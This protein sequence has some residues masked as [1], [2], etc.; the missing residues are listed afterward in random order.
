V[1]GVQEHHAG[2]LVRKKPAKT[3]TRSPHGVAYQHIGWE[4]AGLLQQGA[5]TPCSLG[6]R[7]GHSPARSSRVPRVIGDDT[8]EP[9]RFRL[10]PGPRRGQAAETGFQHDRGE[11][12]AGDL[13]VQH[14]AVDLHQAARRGKLAPVAQ[15][16]KV[17]YKA[18]SPVMQGMMAV[19]SRDLHR[20]P[21]EKTGVRAVLV[22]FVYI[23]LKS[24]LVTSALKLSTLWGYLQYLLPVCHNVVTKVIVVTGIRALQDAH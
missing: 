21:G 18:P 16:G 8:A 11:A 19:Q 24:P 4:H 12:V 13:E 3:R 9:G 5:Q 10:N 17:W 15:R 1:H 20:T 14:A 7:L 23:V 6:R 2:H 22:A